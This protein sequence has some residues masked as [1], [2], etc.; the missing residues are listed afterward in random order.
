MS[1]STSEDQQ[2]PKYLELVGASG[3]RPL[4]DGEVEFENRWVHGPVRSPFALVF[5]VLC[6]EG[7]Q[8]LVVS[9]EVERTHQEPKLHPLRATGDVDVRDG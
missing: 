5:R 9:T 4:C 8:R 7:H 2:D 6:V 3:D 1:K